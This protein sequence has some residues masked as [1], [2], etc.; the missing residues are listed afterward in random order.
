MEKSLPLIRVDARYE[1][2]IE[3]NTACLLGGSYP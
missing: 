2:A 1:R 3:R